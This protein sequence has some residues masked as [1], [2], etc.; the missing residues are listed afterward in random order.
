[1]KTIKR[2][3]S[4]IKKYGNYIKYSISCELKSEVAE[5]RLGAIWWVLEPILTMFIYIFIALVVFKAGEPYFDIFIF[6]GL[7]TY[8]F[9]NSNVISSVK[10]VSGNSNIVTKIYLPK[11]V[12]L[13]TRMGVNAVKY[14][15]CLV[16]VAILLLIHQVPMTIYVFYFIPLFILLVIITFG[17]SCVLLHLGVFVRDLGNV[18]GIAM[19]LVF[20]AS[21][22][23]F[24]IS[25]RVP[26]P[27]DVILLKF[28]PLA[29]LISEIRNAVIYGRGPDL[30]T[31]GIWL[32]IGLFLSWLGVYLIY[33]YENTYV[34]V[35][36]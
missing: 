17:F 7:A 35:I 16:L 11:F 30:L 10:L 28:N 25:T 31:S 15:I 32:A 18:I 36:K 29:L 13:I 12:L 20:Y 1:M 24:L 8:S 22:V 5:S 9:F 6:S 3:V 33:R 26:A 14:A 34:K 4:D 19:K 23:F 21:G 2:F 27:Y